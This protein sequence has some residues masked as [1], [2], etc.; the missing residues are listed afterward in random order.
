MTLVPVETLEARTAL[1][2]EADQEVGCGAQ[3]DQAEE[4][5]VPPA[6]EHVAGG[7]QERVLASHTAAS[8]PVQGEDDRQED[9]EGVRGEEQG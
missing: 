1:E 3:R 5:P 9:R 6:V 7:D 8:E 2:R 4:T